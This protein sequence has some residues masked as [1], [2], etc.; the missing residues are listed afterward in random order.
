MKKSLALAFSLI[1]ALPLYGIA[2]PSI[3]YIDE[4]TFKLDINKLKKYNLVQRLEESRLGEIIFALPNEAGTTVGIKTAPMGLSFK[5]AEEFAAHYYSTLLTSL[6]QSYSQNFPSYKDEVVKESSYKSSKQ[7]S[8]FFAEV[9]LLLEYPK[10]NYIKEFLYVAY[11]TKHPEYVNLVVIDKMSRSSSTAIKTS[12][13]KDFYKALT[14][15][16]SK[17]ELSY[18]QLVLNNFLVDLIPLQSMSLALDEVYKDGFTM[19]NFGTKHPHTHLISIRRYSFIDPDGFKPYSAKAF[20]DY[21]KFAHFD[22]SK[23]TRVEQLKFSTEIDSTDQIIHFNELL[24]D[25]AVPQIAKPMELQQTG[26]FIYN[27]KLNSDFEIG[28]SQRAMPGEINQDLFNMSQDFIYQ[29]IHYR[30]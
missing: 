11:D 1:L 8:V 9:T 27:S 17:I 10:G 12:M 6:K 13:A 29:H 14:F 21:I 20:E 25:N 16:Y 18:P 7:G 24:L 2:Q 15:D 3:P 4:A 5:T 26:Y 28:H 22:R 23:N 30:N 19:R